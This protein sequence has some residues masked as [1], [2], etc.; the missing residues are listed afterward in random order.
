MKVRAPYIA[1]LF[2]YAFYKG[3]SE[4]MLRDYL[5]EKDIDVCN[6][7]NTVTEMEYLN[8]LEALLK[9][10]GDKNFGIHFGCY[11][12]IKALGFIVKLS[13]NSSS[14]EQAV[15]ILQNYLQNTFPLVSL[16]SEEIEGKYILKLTTIIKDIELSHQVL[17]FVYC[18]IYREMRLM[19]SNDF[20]P[21]LE[22]P[23][24]TTTELANFLDAEL[25][26]G[27]GYSFTYDATVLNAE[28]N[29]KALREIEFL[30]PKFLQMLDK[31]NAGY[32]PFGMKVRN[33]VLNMCKPELP[34]FNQVATQFPLSNRTIQR[35]LT[36]EG[37]S[38]R[39]I[40][41]EIKNELSSYLSKGHKMKTQDIAYLLGY[42][43][44]SAYLHA[45]KKW[46]GELEK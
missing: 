12:N 20:I 1:N 24:S 3:V 43:E 6:P 29:K 45:V 5:K 33:M 19:L 34:T 11:L 22:V 28:I 38:F 9:A 35:K 2:E 23:K 31:K 41:N 37:L 21:V 16:E 14:I 13:F 36:D 17:D 25:I 18:F 39:K 7:N 26:R 10:T 46:E 27:V 8:V 30:L 40:T 32:K 44:T 42:S 4:E 15:F